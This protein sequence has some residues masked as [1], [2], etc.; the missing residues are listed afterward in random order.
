MTIT[1]LRGIDVAD[2]T[3]S[4]L[5]FAASME[6]RKE[7]KR[8]RKREEEELELKKSA[9]ATEEK[10][11]LAKLELMEIERQIASLY[12]LPLAKEKLGEAK[13]RTARLHELEKGSEADKLLFT[14][15][16]LD[17]AVSRNR[18]SQL[19]QMSQELRT[20]MA[21]NSFLK[22]QMAADRDAYQKDRDRF[23][24]SFD[25]FLGKG[26]FDTKKAM[27][28][29]V[30]KAAQL[31][32]VSEL[33]GEKMRRTAHDYGKLRVFKT[34]GEPLNFEVAFRYWRRGSIDD[35]AMWIDWDE[36]LSKMGYDWDASTNK[37]TASESEGR[38]KSIWEQESDTDL[39][40]MHPES[41]KKT[42]PT[43][44]LGIR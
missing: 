9:F 10:F 39:V 44:P 43:D 41:K 16:L 42:E 17:G 6:G 37:I 1:A 3:G 30:F 15:V 13:K 2:V 7:R 34:P 33:A 23:A 5:G 8:T 35:A 28:D 19:S 14:D 22:T 27:G 20:W 32:A 29:K 12:S 38:E 36:E 18:Q 26:A 21:E 11:N 24:M 25:M 4:F 31:E 40:P